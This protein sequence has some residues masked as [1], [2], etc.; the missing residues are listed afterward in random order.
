MCMK[1]GERFCARW[2]LKDHAFRG[3]SCT[4]CSQQGPDGTQLAS[5]FAAAWSLIRLA[6]LTLNWPGVCQARR[7]FFWPPP[8]ASWPT[9]ESAMICPGRGALACFARPARRRSPTGTNRRRAH[10]EMTTR[11]A[12]MPLIAESDR[13]ALAARHRL[14]RARP[15]RGA[16]HLPGCGRRAFLAGSSW[17]PTK[18]LANCS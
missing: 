11:D 2:L 8:P 4:D 5:M 17:V 7:V 14:P 6:F 3:A 18:A 15:A 13:A 10:P 9:A 1:N 12:V 16:G